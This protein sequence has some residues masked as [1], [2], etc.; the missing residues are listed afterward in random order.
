VHSP[1]HKLTR[2]V[3]GW[4]KRVN[5]KPKWIVSAK[6]APTGE[7]ADVYYE[8][9]FTDLWTAP[10]DAPPNVAELLT[11][12][13]LADRFIDRKERAEISERSKDE[14]L[15]AMDDFTEAVGDGTLV[16]D[17][18]PADFAKARAAFAVRFGPDR[19][20]KYLIMVRSM[21]KWAARP[22]LRLRVPDYGDEFDLPSRASFRRARKAHREEHGAK[23]FT[24]AE[25]GKLVKS[26]RP[27]LRAMILLAVNGGFG[28]TDVAALPL[29]VVDLKGGWLDYARGKTGID[30][31]V[32]LWQD[33]V[34]AL[35][36]VLASRPRPRDEAYDPL[37]FLTAFGRPYVLEK[38]SRK[39]KLLHKDQVAWQ[40]ANLC[41]S[42]DL[43]RHGRS[44]YSLRRT[45]R[46][47][48]DEFGDQRA[49]AL[50]MGHELADIGSVYVQH[51]ADS[52]LVALTRYVRSRLLP[53]GGA[54]AA[55]RP[56][57]GSPTR[58]AA[59]VAAARKVPKRR[60]G[61]RGR[62]AA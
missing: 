27:K 47:V 7:A 12:A 42:L 61:S 17:L 1:K 56:A 62:P 48:A 50:V 24:P 21:F 23:F 9:N 41:K 33:T 58:P 16:A 60:R 13:D 5:G 11:V 14:Y 55:A 59:S 18:S 10:E 40:F 30:R 15:A 6:V 54:P 36:A 45:F 57:K 20:A 35:A 44:F 4:V 51:V 28:N 38:R 2:T 25:I 3:R 26:A 52:R 22:P 49:A 29:S 31:R 32:P 43:Y 46:T 8:R 37:L 19:L 53:T 34:K 39:G